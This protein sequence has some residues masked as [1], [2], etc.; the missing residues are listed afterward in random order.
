[1]KMIGSMDRYKNS[2]SVRIFE[3]KD[4]YLNL[5]INFRTDKTEVFIETNSI[6]LVF[7]SST[8]AHYKGK[9]L[10]R[11]RLPFKNE[12]PT[13]KFI[14]YGADNTNEII[15]TGINEHNVEC[16]LDAEVFITKYMLE[17]NLIRLENT[18]DN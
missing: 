10:G 15:D 9:I 3:F 16:Y 11:F 2:T 13:I 18:N 14:K 1:M 4:D 17:N 8:N 7:D 5:R 6:G 12:V